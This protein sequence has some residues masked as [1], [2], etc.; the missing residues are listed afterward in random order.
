MWAKITMRRLFQSLTSSR[1]ALYAPFYSSQVF[2]TPRSSSD[3]EAQMISEAA[4]GEFGASGNYYRRLNSTLGTYVLIRRS[5]VLPPK[6]GVYSLT[7]TGNTH[8][9]SQ[10]LIILRGIKKEKPI[11]FFPSY[12]KLSWFISLTTVPPRIPIDTWRYRA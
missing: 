3:T 9:R 11:T 7:D 5:A 8:N 4:L 1:R 6:I 10:T 12:I 2:R